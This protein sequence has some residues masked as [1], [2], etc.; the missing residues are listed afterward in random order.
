[1]K[2]RLLSHYPFYPKFIFIR[3]GAVAYW[4]GLS[5]QAPAKRHRYLESFPPRHH[6]SNV[7]SL[8]PTTTE[9]GTTPKSSINPKGL[10]KFIFFILYLG[11]RIH[12]H[13]NWLSK[14]LKYWLLRRKRIWFKDLFC[15]VIFI[16]VFQHW[17]KIKCA[18]NV[19]RDWIIVWNSHIQ[20]HV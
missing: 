17:W 4:R 16:A 1:M 5:S 20:V 7:F 2:T 3:C 9:E 13:K 12:N 11:H 15:I 19:S 18:C 6:K 14:V 8:R 10:T